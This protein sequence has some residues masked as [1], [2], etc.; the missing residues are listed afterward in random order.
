MF[1]FD[2][3]FRFTYTRRR[4]KSSQLT[5]E[6]SDFFLKTDLFVIF[7]EVH[8]IGPGLLHCNEFQ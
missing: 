7:R 5:G 8:Y 2:V 1:G 4:S 3:P 6:T